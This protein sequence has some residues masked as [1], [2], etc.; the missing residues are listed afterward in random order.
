MPYPIEPRKL[1]IQETLVKEKI[2]KPVLT[3]SGKW[4][5][6]A[7]FEYGSHVEVTNEKPGELTIRVLQS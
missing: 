3:L 7:G 6:D 2:F 1:K 4:L 5:K